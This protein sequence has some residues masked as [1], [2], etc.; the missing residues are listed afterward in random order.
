MIL[1]AWTPHDLSQNFDE[2]CHQPIGAMGLVYINLSPPLLDHQFWRLTMALCLP[3]C[4]GLIG[5]DPWS[6]LPETNSSHLKRDCF[7]RK[8][9][10]QTSIFKGYVSFREGT[11][12]AIGTLLFVSC[13]DLASKTNIFYQ[14]NK[15]SRT[16]ISWGIFGG[17]FLPPVRK[18]KRRTPIL[19]PVFF[20][21]SF[22]S[23]VTMK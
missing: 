3:G 9:I 12:S 17:H 19:G 11:K 18:Q 10:F 23:E 1:Q 6:T 16:K 4:R 22:A 8:Y 7:N 2:R 13:T 5:I 14:P 15:I 21:A 20:F